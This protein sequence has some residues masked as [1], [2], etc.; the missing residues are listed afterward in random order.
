MISFIRGEIL[1]SDGSEVII[2][3]SSGIGYQIYY[4]NILAEGEISGLYISHVIKEAS[5]DLYGFN[6]LKD[7]KL[8]ELLTS[9]KGIG[10]KSAYSLILNL[11]VQQI[12]TALKLDN[13]KLLTQAPGVGP[14]AAAQMILDLSSKI[15]KIKIYSE[16][17]NVTNKE[18]EAGL[19][20]KK[21]GTNLD[22][23]QKNS[24]SLP[25]QNMIEE[26]MMACKELGF[27]EEQIIP[28]AHKLACE[29][30][31]SKPEQLVHL[32]LKEI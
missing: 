32:L 10:P 31:I 15:D 22:L 2:L 23:I 17:Y 24:Q 30:V 25:N 3:T 11:G 29:N 19:Q 8:F 1:F 16:I 9:V 13:K 26:A 6:S 27:K 7:K 21:N 14:K 12:Y 20:D 28:L 4:S 5:E 18:L